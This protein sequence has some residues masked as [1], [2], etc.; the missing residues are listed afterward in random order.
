MDMRDALCQV[1]AK[2]GERR[3]FDARQVFG[4]RVGKHMIFPVGLGSALAKAV[5]E[6]LLV[7]VGEGTRRRGK[8][9]ELT[10]ASVEFLREC[11]QRAGPQSPTPTGASPGRARA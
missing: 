11:A 5:R 3:R 4:K 1:G 10:P 9:Y 7:V 8:T 6:G 2:L